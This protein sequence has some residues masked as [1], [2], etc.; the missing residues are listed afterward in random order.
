MKAPKRILVATDFSDASEAALDYGIALAKALDANIVVVHVYE[1][2]IYGFAGGAMIATSEMVT[3]IMDGAQT[4]C[5]AMC[6]RRKDS[7][8]AISQVVREG[9]SW[10][11]VQRIADEVDADLI[12]VGTRARKGIAH[13]LLGSVAEKIIRT[14]TRPVLTVRANVEPSS[15]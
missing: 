3:A 9:T 10:L 14:A 8:V 5:D 6:A 13:A 2:P 7:G 1:L 12:I 15:A 4:A 11:E